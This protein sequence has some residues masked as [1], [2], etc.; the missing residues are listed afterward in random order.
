V[1]TVLDAS[2][3]LAL[4][5]AEAGAEKVV[6]LVRR[7]RMSAVNLAEVVGKMIERGWEDGD[8]RRTLSRF[9]IAVVSFDSEMAFT[10]GTLRRFTRQ[11]GLS[12][13][14][15]ACLATAMRDGLHVL[16]ADRTWAGLDLGVEIEVIR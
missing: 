14:D 2:A 1:K 3:L 10:T 15:R 11:K 12:F 9:R 6:P 8:I 4:V 7:S 13:G 16:T 5:F